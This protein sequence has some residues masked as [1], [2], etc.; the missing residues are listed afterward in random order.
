MTRE[1]ERVADPAARDDA[2]DEWRRRATLLGRT[3]EVT[4]DGLP[5]LRGTA[6]DIA[7]DGALLVDRER[8]VAG[9][10]RIIG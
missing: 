1:I 10:V 5:T 6:T 8:V 9:E 4:R 3:V 7:D 2:L